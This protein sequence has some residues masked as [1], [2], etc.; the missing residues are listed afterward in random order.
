MEIQQLFGDHCMAQGD[1]VPIS[2]HVAR[3]L[4]ARPPTNAMSIE[5]EIRARGHR[6]R[7]SHAR[8]VPVI[9]IPIVVSSCCRV[10]QHRSRA[11]AGRVLLS[12]SILRM[13]IKLRQGCPS[14]GYVLE[15]DD[16]ESHET[17]SGLSLQPYG[18]GN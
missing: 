13:T 5:W 14:S 4:H 6:R 8:P 12:L 15:E 9:T 18:I 11:D 10:A 7:L 3:L 1:T 16:N 2:S 17:A